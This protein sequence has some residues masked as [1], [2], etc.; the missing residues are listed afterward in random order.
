MA[1]TLVRVPVD[2]LENFVFTAFKAMG[3]SDDDAR[4]CANGLMQSELHCHPG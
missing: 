1:I 3:M 2:A 4:M